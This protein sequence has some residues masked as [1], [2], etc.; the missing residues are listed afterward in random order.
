MSSD[1]NN[2]KRYF[3]RPRV[4][5]PKKESRRAFIEEKMAKLMEL[6]ESSD[7]DYDENKHNKDVQDVQ[8]AEESS[9]EMDDLDLENNSNDEKEEESEYED[10]EIKQKS[11]KRIRKI[12]S[13][14]NVDEDGNL[15]DLIVPDDPNDDIYEQ[16][17]KAKEE[18]W[19]LDTSLLGTVIEHKV[20]SKFPEL[21]ENRKKL[22]VTIIEALKEADEAIVEQ[23]AGAKPNDTIWK[24]GVDEEK[25][26]ELE[27][28]LL[29][30]RERIEEEK[31]TML[32]ILETDMS[33]ADRKKLI[34]I[35]DIYKNMEPYTEEEFEMK[36]R[37]NKSIKV[38]NKN[39]FERRK[40]DAEEDR[41][42]CSAESLSADSLKTKIINLQTS[43]VKKK[44]M[45]EVLQELEETPT[46]STMYR[47][48]KEKLEWMVSLP[49]DAICPL[50]VEFGRSTPE[51]IN[52]F[53]CKVRD[54]LDNDPD[55]GLHGMIEAKDEII[56]ALNNKITNPRSN[57]L[58]CLVGPPGSGK[59]FLASSVATAI[60]LPFERIS[61]GGVDSGF[62]LGS[63][64]HYLGAAPG[65]VLKILRNVKASNPVVLLDEI[66][67]L[68]FDEKGMA[69]QSAVM[70]ITDYTTNKDFRDKYLTDY[71]HDISNIW[72]M[73]SCNSQERLM[74]PLKDRLNILTVENYSHNELKHIACN[75]ALPRILKDV[76]IPGDLVSMDDSGASAILAILGNHIDLEGVRPIQKLIRIIVSRINLLR[77]NTLQD[78]TTGNLHISYK[79]PN[80]K[81]P[82]VIT[83]EIVHRL[84]DKSRM[85]RI[86]SKLHMYM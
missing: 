2:R 48:T 79:I 60:G 64:M 27:P 75:F 71:G 47:S 23:Y 67:K 62:L 38:S 6:S 68:G 46:S 13:D 56:A 65:I 17:K 36:E 84:V 55:I 83:S 5:D 42:M 73:A 41:I 86:S 19:I 12:D 80:F 81:L 49:Y 78:G 18:D 3:L 74:T 63:D 7:E 22:H 4:S 8:E 40:A 70:H 43:D 58:V 54:K 24:L 44:R 69:A 31:P 39:I 25:V 32:K 1:D 76:N 10:E 14:E 21:T 29:E 35:F 11:K 52:A 9:L 77:T 61:L 30:T 28:L 45:L 50:E 72:F 26:K 82:I 20:V 37:I 66:D 57:V 53:C 51:E 15:K 85:A 34:Q 33:S 59:S 16:L